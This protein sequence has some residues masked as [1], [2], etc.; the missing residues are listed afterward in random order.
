[1]LAGAPARLTLV[2]PAEA[3][4]QTLR[5]AGL[6]VRISTEAGNYL[7]EE[8]LFN[9]LHAQSV[10]PSSPVVLFIHTPV[11]GAKVRMPDGSERLMDAALMDQF[12]KAILPAIEKV[13]APT[14]KSAMD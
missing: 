11:L 9:L 14:L 7:C 5:E 8:M 13:A 10:D 2:C 3:L 4:A 12:A 1:M 6:P